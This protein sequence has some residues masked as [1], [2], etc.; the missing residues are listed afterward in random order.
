MVA[1]LAEHYG[2]RRPREEGSPFEAVLA[3]GLGQAA[4]AGRATAAIKA[5]SAADMFEPGILASADPAELIDVVREQ[6]VNLSAKA[7]I[8]AQRLGKW[9][10]AAFP[11]Q[12]QGA[13][14]SSASTS[15]L[16]A[17]LLSLRGIGQATADAILLA[18]GRPCYPVD[19]GSYRILLRHGWIDQTADY[20]EVHQLLNSQA[21]E[22]AAGIAYLSESLVRVGREFCGLAASKCLGC[23]LRAF[24]PENGP[25]EPEG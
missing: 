13:Y 16:R 12:E 14:G 18:L 15:R 20:D 1:A 5:W 7:A 24:L 25:L 21:G 8:L 19:R 6:S 2:L 22:N 11:D 4:D 10:S 3:A 17:E 23:P 9:F